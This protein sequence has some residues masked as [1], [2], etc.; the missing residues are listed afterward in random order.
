MTKKINVIEFED[1]FRI[2]PQCGYGDGFHNMLKRE[3]EGIKW[4]FICPAC[5]AIFDV[6]CMA[7]GCSKISQC[8]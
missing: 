7:P 8:V 5:H 2:C 1:E 4:L 6:G 3:N